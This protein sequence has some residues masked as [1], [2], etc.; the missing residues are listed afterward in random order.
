MRPII[1]I[2]TPKY[3]GR[4]QD[5]FDAVGQKR[6]VPQ[7]RQS[8]ARRADVAAERGLNASF[9]VDTVG[10]SHGDDD[11]QS[12]KEL[13]PHG[14]DVVLVAAALLGAALAGRSDGVIVQLLIDRLKARKDRYI[15]VVGTR[16]TERDFASRQAGSV[17]VAG[18]LSSCPSSPSRRRDSMPAKFN[19]SPY[20][21]E[22]V[23]N[24]AVGRYQPAL[25]VRNAA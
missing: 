9:Q 24:V 13:P 7:E 6:I 16:N 20:A 4:G 23:M 8:I 14:G 18:V 21:A 12:R 17:R 10:G 15:R 3:V 22:C 11:S 25:N 5:L 2:D 1:V 19:K